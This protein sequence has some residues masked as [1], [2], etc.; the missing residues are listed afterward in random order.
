MPIVRT[1]LKGHLSCLICA[2]P[3]NNV[4]VQCDHC[5][6]WCHYECANVTC[7][8]EGENVPWSCQ[9]CIIRKTVAKSTKSHVTSKTKSSKRSSIRT[10]QMKLDLLEEERAMNLA[11][12]KKKEA[13]L[14]EELVEAD[15]DEF[16]TVTDSEY[17]EKRTHEW[18]KK[19]KCAATYTNEFNSQSATTINKS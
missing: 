17:S 16:E 8:V 4:M 19:C 7:E 10:V 14:T 11:Y 3:D 15:D 6:G 2:R 12:L 1:P 18:V 5:D 13:I 9:K